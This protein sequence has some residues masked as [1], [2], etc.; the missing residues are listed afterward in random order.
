MGKAAEK[1]ARLSISSFAPLWKAEASREVK[2]R[3][4]SISARAA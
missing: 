3:G 1:Q 2:I 4:T